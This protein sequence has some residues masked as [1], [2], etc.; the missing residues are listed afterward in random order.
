MKERKRYEDDDGRT[1]ARMDVDGMPW[2]IAKARQERSESREPL[3]LSR[4][5]RWALFKGV[6]AAVLLIGLA[7][8]AAFTLFI[9]FADLV[10]LK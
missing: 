2:Y 9:F 10:W 4:G 5:E 1:I 6:L 7:F 3:H 8:V